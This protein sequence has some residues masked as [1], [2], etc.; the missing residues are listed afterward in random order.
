MR[1]YVVIQIAGIC[2]AYGVPI[3]FSSGDDA[4]NNSAFLQPSQYD[5]RA[6]KILSLSAF[7]E[8]IE[9][10]AS[11]ATSGVTALVLPADDHAPLGF[12]PIDIFSRLGA[13]SLN[14]SQ[15]WSTQTVSAGDATMTLLAGTA[16]TISPRILHIGTEAISPSSYNVPASGTIAISR[17]IFGTLAMPH[18][19]NLSG[20]L[21]RTLPVTTVPVE[22][23]GRRVYVYLDN[24]LWR[25][26]ML[27]DNPSITAQTVTL[28]MIDIVNQLSLAKKT[29]QTPAYAT[30]LAAQTINLSV[31]L[32]QSRPPVSVGV[33]QGSAMVTTPGSFGSNGIFS[34]GTSTTRSRI[35]GLFAWWQK[36]GGWLYRYGSSGLPDLA[37]TIAAS[38]TGGELESSYTLQMAG[39]AGT[40]TLNPANNCSLGPA[41]P[42]PA[43]DDFLSESSSRNYYL[44]RADFGPVTYWADAGFAYLGSSP[45]FGAVEPWYS[46][47]GRSSGLSVSMTADGRL[48]LI[49]RAS[50]QAEYIDWSLFSAPLVFGLIYRR[51]L[52][53]DETAAELQTASSPMEGLYAT[54][55]PSGN[56]NSQSCGP[57]DVNIGN[58]PDYVHA[59]YPI[60]PKTDGDVHNVTVTPRGVVCVLDGYGW[61]RGQATA[62]LDIDYC[63]TGKWWEPGIYQVKTV[64][65]IPLAGGSGEIEIRWQEPGDEWLRAVADVTYVSTSAGVAT[66]TIGQNVTMLDGSPCVGFGSW[67]GLEPCQI[68]PP[69]FI[70]EGSIG[71]ILAQVIASTDSTSGRIADN[72]GDGY[73][74]ALSQSGYLSFLA[75]AS[76]LGTTSYR[77]SPDEDFGYADLLEIACRLT[78][79]SVVG[80]LTNSTIGATTGYGPAFVPMCRPM[81]SEVVAQWTDDDIVGIPTTADGYAGPV[82]VSYKITLGRRTWNSGLDW[83]AADILGQGDEMELDLTPIVRR[84][85]MVDDQSI[86]ELIDRLRDRF[87]VIRRRW[88]LRLPID[89]AIDRNVGDVVA[90]TSAYLADPAGGLGV[91]S[92]LARILSISHDFAAGVSDVELIAY[93][94]YG[95]GWSASYDVYLTGASGA[96]YS[97][98]LTGASSP[99]NPADFRRE[100]DL[101]NYPPTVSSS[102]F[103]YLVS[104]E[105]QAAGGVM[106][107]YLTAW[108]AANHTATFIRTTQ[109]ANPATSYNWRVVL[110]P[111]TIPPAQADLYQVGRDKLM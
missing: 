62:S 55:A 70:R 110:I 69:T 59:F 48:S 1:H 108:N 37:L 52:A 17:G 11:V 77:F 7:S 33:K 30:T 54:W 19:A 8:S 89:I 99:T 46:A 23:I 32:F 10:G 34:G 51:N 105:G 44:R 81:A 25:V 67:H 104:T 18:R 64:G 86:A 49:S 61:A 83:L 26:M 73:S 79:R 43:L 85:K 76:A 47:T 45:D 94:E 60:R 58:D 93:A 109:T 100:E 80:R 35:L 22:W 71:G 103:Y 28:S 68:L 66:Y 9:D 107:G 82:F 24:R 21:A 3:V 56:L 88:A 74:V 84:P 20:F 102:A 92:R 75:A 72:L 95:A 90:V 5:L 97:L 36:N 31:D 41:T 16:Q 50:A 57:I 13:E 63:E 38:P 42:G 29:S 87:G 91:S 106:E 4:A 40:A 6:G 53:G 111:S 2:N 96:T 101:A 78:G 15:V 98:Q 65:E 12:R 27:A 14:S 39:G